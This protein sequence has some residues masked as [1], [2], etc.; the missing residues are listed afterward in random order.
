MGSKI[1]RNTNNTLIKIIEKFKN[2]SFYV[3]IYDE[4]Y[5]KQKD[6]ASYKQIIGVEFF[7]KIIKIKKKKIKLQLWQ[8]DNQE[9]FKYLLNQFFRGSNCVIIMY[10]IANAESLKVLP[11][12]IH[13]ISEM[14]GDIP[15]LLVG[16]KVDKEKEREVSKEEG[17][18]FTKNNEL[19][20][21]I[22]ISAKKGQNCEKVFEILTKNLT[23]QLNY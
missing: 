15:I 19:F 7:K 17:I 4:G 5:R 21:F 1:I 6:Q 8:L 12:F 11:E 9:R 13:I 22:E 18:A 23:D 16:N 3:E 10:D 14:S 20:N 2:Y